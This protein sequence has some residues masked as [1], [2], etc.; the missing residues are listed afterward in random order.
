MSSN[1][2]G[3]SEDRMHQWLARRTPAILLKGRTGHD[4]AVFKNP[5][6]LSVQCADQCVEGVH[7]EREVRGRAVGRKAANRALSDL[8]ATA[9][10]PL[11]I[12][13]T[14]S[15]PRERPER[16]LK[17]VIEGASEAA[18]DVG[19]ALVGGD[20][21]I[22]QGQAVISVFA[23]GRL[24]S[25]RK[26]PGRDRARAGQC[27]VLTGPVGGSRASR[28]LRFEPKFSEGQE[29]FAAGA[30]AMMDVSDGLAWDLHRLARSSAV[31]IDLEN[32]PIHRDA[33]K[34]SR[35]SGRAAIDHALHDG[36][37][38]ELIACLLESKRPDWAHQIGTVKAGSG[39]WLAPSL[40][41]LE[42]L[43]QWQPDEGGWT[44]G[45]R[46]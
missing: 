30:S 19:A 37:D 42:T 29:L 15:V 7:F 28:H 1:N 5:R 22:C 3:W 36:E 44:H 6:G 12:L 4:A 40:T 23:S 2:Q 13:L 35:A 16:W 41:G 32:V 39:L 43:R 18:L 45:S 21:S 46:D 33:K 24:P 26:P 10:E 17:A 25:K 38:H 8:A 9:A 14:M 34:A 31:R 11:S 20:L 27:V